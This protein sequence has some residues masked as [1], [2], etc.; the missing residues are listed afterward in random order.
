MG[1]TVIAAKQKN[2]PTYTGTHIFAVGQYSWDKLVVT[3]SYLVWDT[4]FKILSELFGT[5]KPSVFGR[6]IVLLPTVYIAECA[7]SQPQMWPRA[8][9]SQCLLSKLCRK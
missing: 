5:G 4:A 9:R 8:I 1:E 2:T 6:F 3:I 7:V